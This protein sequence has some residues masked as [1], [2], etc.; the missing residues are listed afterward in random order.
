VNLTNANQWYDGPSLS[1]AA[2]TWLLTAQ[3][4]LDGNASTG[5]H[6]MGARLSDGTTH[7]VAAEARLDGNAANKVTVP[8][9]TIVTL[10]S[11]T[12][13][14]LQAICSATGPAILKAASVVN[15][16]GN[17]NTQISAVKIG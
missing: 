10:G 8:L 15:G 5:T 16:S 9:V 12:T 7:Y 4:H 17:V 11:T 13:V 14:K 1:L 2:G 3:A 6:L